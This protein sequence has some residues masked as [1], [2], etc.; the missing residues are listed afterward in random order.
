M[1]RQGMADGKPHERKMMEPRRTQGIPPAPP[2][3][4]PTLKLEKVESPMAY[5][6]RV[7]RAEAEATDREI[8]GMALLAAA[9]CMGGEPAE[10][11]VSLAT[12]F[13]GYIRN[14]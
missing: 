10:H 9:T 5:V 3:A 14:G 7:E 1:A 2:P 8:R 12:R 13:E 6:A 4:G 11:V